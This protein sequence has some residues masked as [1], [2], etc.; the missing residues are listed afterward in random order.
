MTESKAGGKPL[1]VWVEDNKDYQ[2]VVREWL[3]P[4][5]DVVT[6]EDGERFLDDLEVLEPDLVML[7]MRLPGPDGFKLCRKIRADHRLRD[8]PILFLT[9][10]E[11]DEAYIEHLNVGG[12]GLATK[13]IGKT[14]LLAAVGELVDG[15]RNTI[16]A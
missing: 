8:V 16:G 13:P 14:R 6:Y 7:D 3:V 12:T 1:I 2:T 11:G 9:S 10:D 4:K 15:Q 5:Y